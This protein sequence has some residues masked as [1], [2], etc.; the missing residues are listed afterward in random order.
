M[1]KALAAP[2]DTFAKELNKVKIS[3][4]I[5][6]SNRLISM[7]KPEFDENVKKYTDILKRYKTIDDRFKIAGN[8]PAQYEE[9][10]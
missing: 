9:Y 10:L 5:G 1:Q 7:D 2:Y 8:M 6:L 4:P 3:I